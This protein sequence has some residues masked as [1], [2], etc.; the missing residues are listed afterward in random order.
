[1]AILRFKAIELA[2]N[3][4][5]VVVERPADKVSDFFGSN[6]F[7]DQA[8]K[9]YLS[10][11]NYKKLVA[12][13]DTGSRIDSELADAVASAMKTWALSKGV[14][15]YTHW[16]QPLT[17]ATAE[18]HDAFFDIDGK[19]GVM[20]KFKG[21]ALVQQEP[22]A[23]SFPSG[24]IRATFEARGYTGWD[25]TSPA[26][27]MEIEGSKT[28]CIPT[29]FVSYT[30][31]ALDYKT[32]L[33]KS[34]HFVD[35]AAVEV[36]QMFDKDITKVIATLGPEQE[37]F[38][39]DKALYY[40]RPDLVMSGKTVFGH[41]P[42]KGQQLE[43]H[44]FGSIP[45]RVRA[46]M[47]DFETE[48]QKLGIPVRTRHNEVAPAQFECAPTFEEVNLA[49]DHNILLMDVMEKVA[50]RHDFKVLFHEKPFAGINGSGK[51]N[52][53]ALGTNTGKNLLAPTSK[54]KENL[55]FLTF[56]VN[57]IKAVYDNADL[58]RASIASA[59]NDYRLGANE[60][61]PAIISVFVGAEM[62]RVLEELEKNAAVK[63]EKGDNLY[64]KLGI[65]KI[66]QLILDTTDRNR[67]SPFAFTGNKFEFRAVGGSAN[68]A[69]AMTILNMIVAHQLV[70]FKKDVEDES[71]KTDKKELAIINVLRKYVKSSKKV[72]FEGDGYSEEWRKEAEKR[73]LPNVKST[74][75]ALDAL[76]TKKAIKIFEETGVLSHREAEARHE[77]QLENY[78]KKVQIESRVMGDLALNHVIPAAVT[79]QNKLIANVKGLKDLGLNTESVKTI[80][81]AIENVSH[82]ISVV[83][84]NVKA[85]ID[86]RKEANLIEDTR[87]RAIAY[88]EK[89]KPYFDTIRYSVD[90]L[91]LIVDDEDWPLAKYRELLM[92]R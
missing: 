46:F 14:T 20:E 88:D 76:V 49:N 83:Q 72:I 79:Y 54:P 38:L 90:K 22:D 50:E 1:M 19:G 63:I 10:A 5:S 52:N 82:H 42:A 51:H 70:Q 69:G 23:S 29:I 11:D 80:T 45:S 68:C 27:I 40:A 24:G 3:R 33:L 61:P 34:L 66:P 13:T 87:A 12:A 2:Q 47:I 17:G 8:M 85:M 6:V 30:S 36:C 25:P 92:I 75:L 35:K 39:I 55:Q 67:T 32:P 18:K 26:F 89:I 60:A 21:S 62:M 86:A 84:A 56:F 64:M 53:W 65:S 58:L 74:P 59:G 57:T 44:Y 78:I 73:G 15:H 28:L 37:Y 91:E 31:D 71:K 16:F 48:C 41:A 7:G 9:T 43:D 4:P 77:V 81:D